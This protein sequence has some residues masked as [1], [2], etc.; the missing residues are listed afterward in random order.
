MGQATRAR[1]GQ[2]FGGGHA[3]GKFPDAV[4]YRTAGP[5]PD[6]ATFAGPDGDAVPA[7]DRHAAADRNAACHEPVRHRTADPHA[8]LGTEHAGN[9]VAAAGEREGFAAPLCGRGMTGPGRWLAVAARATAAP[10]ERK[11]SCRRQCVSRITAGSRCST[12]EV[13][14]AAARLPGRT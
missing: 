11:V 13:A 14:A 9:A 7:G 6:G 12:G 3:A 5:P 2:R 10:E 8:H 4:T 1:H